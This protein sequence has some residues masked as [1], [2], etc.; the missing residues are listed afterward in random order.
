MNEFRK[1]TGKLTAITPIAIGS[2]NKI[3]PFEYW[4]EGDKISVGNFEKLINALMDAEWEKNYKKLLD[5]FA[6]ISRKTF[7]DMLKSFRL[8]SRKS[9]FVVREIE[10]GSDESIET[11]IEEFI[12]HPNGNIFIPGSSI[13]GAIMTALLN[14]G[15][16]SGFDDSKNISVS[17]IEVA[18]K[19]KISRTLYRISRLGMKNRGGKSNLNAVECVKA[20]DIDVQFGIRIDDRE[21]IAKVNEFYLNA[22]NKIVCI[23]PVK[24]NKEI[25][26]WLERIKSFFSPNCMVFQ[27]GH[28][29]SNF[30]KSYSERPLKTF[31]ATSSGI[32]LGWV[33]IKFQ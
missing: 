12:A 25:I 4:Q 19:T 17:D 32:P 8:E 11:E 2:G 6:D 10:K 7:L 15:A 16:L 1:L 31:P 21:F 27:L 5:L 23:Q 20:E 13:K 14:G 9:E 30:T 28:Y 3:Y 29:G 33:C 18:D 26:K 24:N 22:I